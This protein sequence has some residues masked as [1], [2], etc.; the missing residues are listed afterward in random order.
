MRQ[1]AYLIAGQHF[2]LESPGF[3]AA[4]MS[5]HATHHR[6][7]CLCR[8]NGVEMY[9]ARS[10]GGYIIKRMP[11]SGS[12]HAP[13][14]LSYEP[15][16]EFSGLGQVLGSAITEDPVTG[17]TTLR[18]DFSM[19]KIMG[20]STMPTAG[21]GSDSVATDGTRLSLRGLLHYLWDQGELTR[22][23]P[24]FLG[25]RSWATVRKQ[26]LQAAVNKMACGGTLDTRLYVPEVFNVEQRTMINARRMA[27]WNREAPTNKPERLMLLIAELKEIVPARYGFNAVVKHVTDQAFALDEYLYR[28]VV[29]HFGPELSMWGSDSRLHMVMI[30]TF[31]VNK[32]GVP[33]IVE[34][35]LMPVTAQWL[36]IEDS[37]EEQLIERLVRD[38]RSFVKGLRYHLP[39][40]Q[41]L[42]SVT[43]IDAGDAPVALSITT[44][45]D[46]GRTVN[47]AISV[48]ESSGGW[49]SWVWR[50][51][52]G[53]MPALPPVA[54]SPATAYRHPR[55]A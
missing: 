35:S 46:H 26:L 19:S 5:A 3:A 6:P 54:R 2:E 38:G 53:L 44:G 49:R 30:A 39:T 18:L 41:A 9:V 11:D 8:I 16:A 43:L 48:G 37:F 25:R 24:A 21:N 15:P 29:R 28:R 52:Q 20:R 33:T 50:I 45:G 4:I 7:R 47:G 27:H 34:M 36:P 55:D 13:D 10:G 22:W 23:R 32:T 42:A 12:Q 31:S 14:C 17:E 40:A 1:G 51:D